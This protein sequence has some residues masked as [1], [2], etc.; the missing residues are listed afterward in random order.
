[1]S[2]SDAAKRAKA[3]YVE[4]HPERVAASKEKYRTE[5]PDKVRETNQR[6]YQANKEK[7]NARCKAYRDSGKHTE[8]NRRWREK[9]REKVRAHGVLG[10]HLKKGNITKQPCEGCGA[11]KVHAHH[12]DYSKPLEVKWFCPQCHKDYHAK[13]EK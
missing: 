9:N 4:R 13:Q 7:V 6:Y 2:D 12:D 8:N 3:N 5:N 11:E 10:Y 1:M